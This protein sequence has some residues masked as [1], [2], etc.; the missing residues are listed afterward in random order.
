MPWTQYK[1]PID[2]FSDSLIIVSIKILCIRNGIL[3]LM[4][5]LLV[6]CVHQKVALALITCI[7]A[8]TVMGLMRVGIGQ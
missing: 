4:P 3:R 5:R 2:Y 1:R 6:K 8:L 7:S